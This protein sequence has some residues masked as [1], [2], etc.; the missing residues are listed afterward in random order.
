VIPLVEVDSGLVGAFTITIPLLV[1]FF[2]RALDGITG[3]NVSVANAYLADITEETE[4][5]TNFGK[6]AIFGNIGF[7]LGPALAGALGATIWGEIPPVVAALVISA[8]ASLIIAFKLPET[9]CAARAVSPEPGTVGK[10]LGQELKECYELE[11]GSKLTMKEILALPSIPLLLALYFL[12]FLAFN[13][14]YIVFPVHAATVLEWSLAEIGAFFTFMGMAMVVVQGPILK[15]ASRVWSERALVIDGSLVLA[16]SFLF[17]TVDGK[18]EAYI[19]TTLLALGNGLMWPSLMALLSMATGREEQGAVQGFASSG[20]AV[21]SILGLLVGGLLYGVL[22]T[23][24]FLLAFAI[25]MIVMV[26]AMWLPSR[27]ALP[28]GSA[29]L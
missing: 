16:V 1:L 14:F 6:M 27:A 10:A 18:P 13:F 20:G 23:G 2:A 24:V 5:S 4:R 19:G 8:V 9:G 15:R 25:T 17:F 12:V 29:A 11:G 28:V 21:A 26:L 7:I 22:G 3:G